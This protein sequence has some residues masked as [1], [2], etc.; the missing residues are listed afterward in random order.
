[1]IA[2]DLAYELT[3]GAACAM[4]ARPAP[5]RPLTAPHFRHGLLISSLVYAPLC[6]AGFTA[7]PG[8]QSMY[9]LDL[10][11][12]FIS[13]TFAALSTAAL[14]LSYILGYSLTA[15]LLRRLP[16]RPLILSL[17][18]AW[19]ILL[20]TLFAVLHPRA[21]WITTYRTFH[22]AH[23]PDLAWG[24]PSSVLGGPATL[25]LLLSALANAASLLWL[26]TR[27]RSSRA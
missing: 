13:A 25:F 21:L 20:V 8:W 17:A 2:F 22:T 11:P 12:P 3:L 19:T 14:I 5:S 10:A 15:A 9:L 27:P 7:F 26:I 16:P 18:A 23:P 1:M 6:V 4:L 24:A